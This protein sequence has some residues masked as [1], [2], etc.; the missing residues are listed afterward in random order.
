MSDIKHYILTRYNVATPGRWE[1][2]RLRPH[3]LE[4]RFDLFR[5]YCL[6][7]IASQ[8]RKDFEWIIFFD[9]KTPPDYMERIKALQSHFPFRI[10]Y[11]DMFEMNVMCRQLISERNDSE[12]LLT[13]RLDSDDNLAKD[14]VERLRNA[15]K[16]G[17]KQNINF[18]NGLILSIKDGKYALYQDRDESSPFASLL[19]PFSDNITTI[20]EK[21]HRHIDEIAPIIQAGDAPAWLQIVHGDN[22]SNHVRGIRSLMAKHTTSFP[23]LATLK[24]SSPE[25]RA[26]ILIENLLVTPWRVAKETLKNFVK[27]LIGR[28]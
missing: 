7:G 12:W 22:I 23:L 2:I 25:T 8:T 17:V 21:Q 18:P 3:W 26:D 11:T 16:T 5:D 10:E 19:E 15:A 27:K 14:F 9:S 24:I 20:W 13:T 6:P 1:E 28:R 4:K